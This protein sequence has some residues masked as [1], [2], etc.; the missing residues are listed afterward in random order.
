MRDEKIENL[1]SYA[2]NEHRYQYFMLIIF[3]FL[4]MNCNFMAVV[5]PYLER[6]PL[7]KY[8]DENNIIHTNE[9]LSSEIC[10]KNYEILERFG[11][12]WISEFD[13]E[14][15]KLYI[16]LI[17][18][19]TFIG[20]TMGSIVFSIITKYFT[21]KKIL[22]VSSV[23]FSLSIYF[24]TIIY[25]VNCF[26][27]I[28]IFLIFVG[29]FGNCLCYSSLVVCEEIISSRKRS[30]F[31]SIINMGYG[32][33]G[34]M[35]SLIFMYIQNWRYDF[36]ILIGCS[37]F[38]GLII[39]LF[40]YDSPRIYIDNK[41]YETTKKILEGIASFNGLKKEF[42]EKIE[43]EECKKLIKE[44]MEYN[45]END[46]NGGIEMKN[47]DSNNVDDKENELIK[48]N[49]KT[50]KRKI[51]K[52]KITAFSSLK[53]PSLRYKFLIL[54]ILWFGTRTT[55]NCIALS[56]KALPGNYYYNIILLFIFES[57]AYYVSGILINI[58]TL[59]RKGT[60]WSQYFIISLTFILLS[61]IK[62]SNSIE[63]GLNYLARFCAAA[64]ELVFYT[65]TLEVYPTP[66]RSL[67]FGIN[68]TFGNIGSILSPLVYEYL[69][70][71][72]F[73]F[74]FALFSLIHAILLIFLPETVGKPMIESI[75]EL[76]EK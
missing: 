55:S 60:L 63:L 12:S 73:L 57:S 74:I 76:N 75:D 39:W 54:C 34:I 6:G 46:E 17:G 21:H 70:N 7:I 65:Y 16:G 19:F 68:V 42:L 15:N 30:F 52:V 1:L 59:G 41:D 67:N 62:F 31:S 50:I 71:W 53:Y 48:F 69:P 2:G 49:E 18:V 36:Y 66:V 51:K 29:L 37:L 3:L 43:T 11:Y 20:N 23:G 24:C 47:I 56:S 33:C 45:Y 4:W 9:T 22:L 40:I 13:I 72:L 64:I 44:I 5:L 35:Y 38:L 8:T 14:C 28:F 25:S 32:L 26:Y 61:F 27:W 10:G 58:K